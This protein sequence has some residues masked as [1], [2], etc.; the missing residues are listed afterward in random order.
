M[1]ASVGFG[2]F[3]LFLAGIALVSLINMRQQASTVPTVEQLSANP[4]RP[5]NIR[6]M[7]ID[8]D[9]K[10]YVQFGDDGQLT[11]HGGCNNF[12]S[13]YRVEGEKIHV[14]A[15]SVT[16]KSC[17]PGTMAVELSFIEA[18]Q[19]ATNIHG[20]GTRMAMKDDR[21]ESTVRFVAIDQPPPE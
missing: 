10:L 5:S 2:F 16:R 14:D 8:S 18:L 1:K 19:L 6:E 20:V 9:S 21:G 17:E 11:G 13:R 7:K 4:W 3:L 15:I 12:F